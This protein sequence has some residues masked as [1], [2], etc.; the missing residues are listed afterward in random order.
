M[1][2]IVKYWSKREVND[3]ENNFYLI[4]LGWS[5]DNQA[6]ADNMAEKKLEAILLKIKSG[7]FSRSAKRDW[8]KY[9]SGK[10]L[11]E[12]LIEEFRNNNDG[13]FAAI[14]RSRTG[15]LVLNTA[16]LA[17]IDIDYPSAPINFLKDFIISIF[18]PQKRTLQ[19]AEFQTS[20]NEKVQNTAQELEDDYSF[21]IY[22]TKA[23]ARVIVTNKKIDPT[24]SESD[25]LMEA[26][27]ADKLYRK[28]CHYQDT[29]R[30]RLTPKPWRIPGAKLGKYPFSWPFANEDEKNDCRSWEN[31][32]NTL[33][34]NIATCHLLYETTGGDILPEFAEIIERHDELTKIN[35]KDLPLA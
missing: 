32:Y 5:N 24:S 3:K 26:F 2:N 11:R 4:G 6:E 12:E 7:D 29:Y 10:P 23:G 14:T 33:S 22:K 19:V 34:E 13:L 16:N 20:L 30:A 35:Q 1:K 18:Q 21:R 28:L 31:K 9:Y 25:N 8:K 15:V 17:L 27:E